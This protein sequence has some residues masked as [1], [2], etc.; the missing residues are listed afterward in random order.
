MQ[1]ISATELLD[2]WEQGLDQTSSQRALSILSALNPDIPFDKLARMPVGLRDRQLLLLRDEIFGSDMIAVIN[3]P[4]CGESIETNFSTS[5]VYFDPDVDLQEILSAQF[6]DYSVE[7]RL[8]NS[9]DLNVISDLQYLKSAKKILIKRCILKIRQE[10]VEITHDQLPDDILNAILGLMD[11]ADPFVNIHLNLICP[12]CNH[13][14]QE[15]FDILSFFWNEIESW[16][17]HTLDEVH[18]LAKAYG[19]SESEILSIGARRRQLYLE[20]MIE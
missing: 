20:R 17:N 14:W 15:Q 3:C 16:A 18:L 4:K 7:F 6:H 8:P 1:P 9:Q 5:D 2:I 19:W 13:E 10:D 12:M 11:E